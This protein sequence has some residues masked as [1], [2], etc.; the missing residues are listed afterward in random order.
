MLSVLGARLLEISHV[1]LVAETRR[2]TDSL[3]LVAVAVVTVA[4][5]L[6]DR[7]DTLEALV[8]VVKTMSVRMFLAQGLL[9]K[10]TQEDR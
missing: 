1:V 4:R 10:G 7:V 8:A 2:L 6:Q 3:Q 5:L 9:D